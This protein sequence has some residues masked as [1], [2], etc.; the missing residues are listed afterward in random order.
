MKIYTPISSHLPFPAF[1]GFTP[2][3]KSSHVDWL[4]RATRMARS[5]EGVHIRRTRDCA[6]VSTSVESK[7]CWIKS[8]C[9]GER[10]SLSIV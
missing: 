8:A 6:L 10:F 7:R 2:L 4:G 1:R 3:T 5:R 9:G